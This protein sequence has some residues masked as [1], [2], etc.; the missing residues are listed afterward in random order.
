MRILL[1]INP[2]PP[3][4]GYVRHAYRLAMLTTLPLH[5]PW[6]QSHYLALTAGGLYSDPSLAEEFNFHF[7]PM[8]DYVPPGL[9]IGGVH[10]DLVISDDRSALPFLVECLRRGIY[11]HLFVDEYHLPHKRA[12]GTQHFSHQTLVFGC[13]SS[14]GIVY[15]LGFDGAQNFGIT[16]VDARALQRAFASYEFEPWKPVERIDL[17]QVR[18][19]TDYAFDPEWVRRQLR[20]YLSGR[21]PGSRYPVATNPGGGHHGLMT[22]DALAAHLEHSAKMGV[23]DVR[24]LH[25]FMEHKERMASRMRYMMENGWAEQ[26]AGIVEAY[27]D[28]VLG[29]ARSRMMGIKFGVSG[30]VDV[31]RRAAEQLE[32]LKEQE[33]QVLAMFTDCIRVEPAAKPAGQTC[34]EPA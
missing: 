8:Y 9:V 14:A 5:A 25:L 32:A 17:F 4:V 30:K 16:A 34:Y 7:A 29:A 3:V 12:Y 10:R 2:S 11:V 26:E 21:D 15:V 22:Y 19:E 28:V 24:P 23:F 6:I 18:P 1:P 31:L 27:D 13:D 20:D 33:R